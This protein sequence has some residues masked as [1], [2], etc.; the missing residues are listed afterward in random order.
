MR[1]EDLYLNHPRNMPTKTKNPLLSIPLKNKSH[2][3]PTTNT[4]AE[5]T[6]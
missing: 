2:G 5:T 4:Q 3:Y 1:R 6:G